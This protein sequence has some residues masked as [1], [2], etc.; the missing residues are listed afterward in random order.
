MPHFKLPRS[1]VDRDQ[2]IL[3]AAEGKTVLHLGCADYPFTEERVADGSWLHAKISAV[4]ESCL[5]LDIDEDTV[6][7]LRNRHGIK[8]IMIGDAECLNTLA[9]KHF[10][11]IVAGEL[12]EHLNNPGLFL[13]TAGQVLAPKGKLIITTTNAYCLRRLVRI[14]FGYESI[15]PDHT[16]YFSHSTLCTLFERF[17]YKLLTATSYR[18]PNRKPLFPY[19]IERLATAISPNLGEGIIHVYSLNQ[20]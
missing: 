14:P 12:I 9:P 5:G 8:N 20:L 19:L 17:H 13:K 6:N 3:A 18:I 2:F 16:C 7:F 4:A 15:H 10:D 11:L 1:L